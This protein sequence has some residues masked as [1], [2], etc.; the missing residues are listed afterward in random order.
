[1]S[2]GALAHQVGDV[3]ALVA[4]GRARRNGE[5]QVDA[6]RAGAIVPLTAAAGLGSEPT[7][8]LVGRQVEGLRVDAEHHVAAGSAIAAVGAG[9]RLVGLAREVAAACAAVA[10]PHA[11]GH[12]VDEHEPIIPPDGT[13]P[14]W[15]SRWRTSPHRASGW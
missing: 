6:A 2:R 12:G 15:A 5:D 13:L 4:N 14:I 9:A 11:D 7:A 1:H 3:A 8:L 10:G